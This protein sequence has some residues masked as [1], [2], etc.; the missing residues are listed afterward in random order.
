MF[1]SLKLLYGL[2]DHEQRKKLHALQIL[3]IFGSVAEVASVLAIGG[4]MTLLGDFN[5]SSLDG[6]SGYLFHLFGF[7]NKNSFII[8][9]NDDLLFNI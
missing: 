8:F 2:L 6:F 4:F 5:Q 9:I 7:Y 1:T 3:V